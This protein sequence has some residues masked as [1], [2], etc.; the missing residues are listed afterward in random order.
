MS[1]EECSSQQC[2]LFP[3]TTRKSR[4]NGRRRTPIDDFREEGSVTRDV[5]HPDHAEQVKARTEAPAA[6]A[7]RVA[8]ERQAVAAGR[9]VRAD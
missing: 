8:V 6:R 2:A 7:Q 9:L 3:A 5:P 4:P 1:H